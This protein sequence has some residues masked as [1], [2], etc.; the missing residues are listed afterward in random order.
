M[1]VT[2]SQAATQQL[3]R[4]RHTRHT[5]TD[6]QLKKS[7][8]QGQQAGPFYKEGTL[9]SQHQQQRRSL[10][11]PNKAQGGQHAVD[12]PGGVHVKP[13]SK[14]GL[15]TSLTAGKGKSKGARPAEICT[16]QKPEGPNQVAGAL[17]KGKKNASSR[18][19]PAELEVPFGP[20]AEGRKALASKGHPKGLPAH[21]VVKGK[22]PAGVKQQ[23]IVGTQSPAQA[24]KVALDAKEEPA[25]SPV[26]SDSNAHGEQLSADALHLLLGLGKGKRKRTATKPLHMEEDSEAEEQA[27]SK[28][29]GMGGKLKEE[30]VYR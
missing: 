23:A 24:G 15:H 27:G 11:Q 9:S 26:Q 6:T 22:S 25:A 19:E 20:S 18:W 5:D 29:Q 14:Q 28:H 21:P 12:P 17:K 2:N 1:L 3:P 30:Q 13:H 10:R 8:G 7:E 16:E 4:L